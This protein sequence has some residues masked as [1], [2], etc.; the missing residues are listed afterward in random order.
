[1]TE[2]HKYKVIQ[3]NHHEYQEVDDGQNSHTGHAQHAKL[4]IHQQ[5]SPELDRGDLAYRRPPFG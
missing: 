3:E 4:P 1:M 2:P 5:L